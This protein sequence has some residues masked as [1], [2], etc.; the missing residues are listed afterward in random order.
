MSARNCVRARFR[1]PCYERLNEALHFIFRILLI[2][3]DEEGRRL[4]RSQKELKFLLQHHA[5]PDF[6]V[7]GGHRRPLAPEFERDEAADRR[8]ARCQRAADD[9]GAVARQDA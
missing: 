6:Q 8:L 1:R 2:V 3:D 7:V 9:K 4:Q 5:G